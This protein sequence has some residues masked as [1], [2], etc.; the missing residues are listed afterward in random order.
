MYEA[1]G[2]GDNQKTLRIM[3]SMLCVRACLMCIVLLCKLR[4]RL[5]DVWS[6]VWKFVYA[7]LHVCVRVCIIFI[8]CMY[9]VM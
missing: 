1:A 5:V 9:G 3:R 2:V 4:M 8:I 7:R 6:E